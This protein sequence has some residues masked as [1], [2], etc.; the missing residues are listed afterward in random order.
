M[1]E[2]QMEQRYKVLIR[3]GASGALVN[4]NINNIKGSK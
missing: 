2:I 1:E 4:I 3:A